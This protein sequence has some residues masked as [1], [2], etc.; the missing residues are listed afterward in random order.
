M[1]GLV[2]AADNL[3]P[4]PDPTRQYGVA[5][6]GPAGGDPRNLAAALTIGLANSWTV[7]HRDAADQAIVRFSADVVDLVGHE[8]L[9]TTF[10][11]AEL[12]AYAALEEIEFAAYCS[13]LIDREDP[14]PQPARAAEPP[15]DR[16]NA[17]RAFVAMSRVDPARRIPTKRL[18][19]PSTGPGRPGP[20]R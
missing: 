20:G 19:R 1:I 5:N 13:A 3:P 10:L 18:I 6:A 16:P 15:T 14:T 7:G 17:A 2:Q 11:V 12:P 4:G 9:T 8:R